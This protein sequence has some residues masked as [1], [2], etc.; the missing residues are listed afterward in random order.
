MIPTLSTFVKRS[1]W[2]ARMRSPDDPLRDYE[3]GGVGVGDASQG[4]SSYDWT[5]FFD[6]TSS[7]IYLYREDLGESSKVLLLNHAG[8]TRIAL[9]FDQNMRPLLA[10]AAGT[11]TSLWRYSS[12]GGG[13]YITTPIAGAR[14]PCITLDERRPEGVSNS[15]VILS[16]TKDD[17]HLYCRVQRESYGTERKLSTDPVPDPTLLA[18]GMTKECRLQWRLAP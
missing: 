14:T 15:D 2:A 9:A 6:S 7:N 16:Y 1:E 12:S 4:L 17:G 8:I 18:C 13:G 5:A 11:G 3:R 10:W